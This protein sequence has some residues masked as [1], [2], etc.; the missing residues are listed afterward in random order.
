MNDLTDAVDSLMRDRQRARLTAATALDDDPDDAARAQQLSLDTGVP[1]S[2]IHGDLEGFERT[3]KGSLNK[4]LI[5]N[6]PHLQEYVNSHPMAA[7]VSHDDFHNLDSVTDAVKAIGS[8]GV[9]GFKA[10]FDYP[11]LVDEMQK[12]HD[13]VDSPLWKEFAK[14]PSVA[15]SAA[16]IEAGKRIFSGAITAGAQLIGEAFYQMSG[17]RAWADRLTRDMY[18]LAQ[19]S[20][21]GQAGFHLAPELSAHA[22]VAEAAQRV[23][24]GVKAAE[25]WLENNQLPPRGIHPVFDEAWEEAS[26]DDI[27]KLD[28]ALRTANQSKTRERSPELFS[29]FVKQIVGNGKIEIDA[30]AVRKLYGED[31]PE[32][33]DGKLGWVPN[34]RQQLETAEATGGSIEVPISEWLARVDPEIAKGLREDTRVR[35]QGMTLKEIEEGEERKEA[36]AKE[37]EEKFEPEDEPPAEDEV[38]A[39]RRV[40]GIEEPLFSEFGGRIRGAGEY[41]TSLIPEDAEKGGEVPHPTGSEVKVPRISGTTLGNLIDRLDF[42]NI[43]EGDKL[44]NEFYGKRLKE[45]VGNVPVHIVGEDSMEQLLSHRPGKGM[46]PGYYSPRYDHI[47]LADYTVNGE[48]PGWFTTKLV[49]H[50]GDHALNSPA[51]LKYPVLNAATEMV[52]KDADIHIAGK[53]AK[54]RKAFDYAFQNPREFMAEVRSRPALRKWLAQAPASLETIKTVQKIADVLGIKDKIVSTWDAVRVIFKD[55]YNRVLGRVPRDSVLDQVF[56]L[57]EILE[58]ANVALEK[59]AKDQGIGKG[60]LLLKAESPDLAEGDKPMF[61]KMAI[62]MNKQWQEKYFKLIEKRNVEDMEKQFKD[63]ERDER[64]RQTE[65]WKQ[66]AQK[67]YSTVQQDL[68]GRPD[69]AIGTFFEQGTIFGQ[70][71]SAKPILDS[72]KLSAEQKAILPKA[73]FGR[74]GIDPDDLAG[75]FGLRSGDEV[76]QVLAQ[77]NKAKGDM[78]FKEYVRQIT[79]KEVS[80]R[81][82]REHGDLEENIMNEAIGHVIGSTQMDILHEELVGLGMRLGRELP[83]TKEDTKAFAKTKFDSTPVGQITVEKMLR[84]AGKAGTDAEL[85][86]LDNKPEEAFQAKQKQYLSMRMADEAKRFEKEQRRFDKLTKQFSAR[87]VKSVLPEYTNFIHQILMQIG[88]PVRRS[89]QDLQAAIQQSGY[90]DLAGFVQAKEGSLREM[91]VAEFLFDPN[92]K[93]QTEDMSVGELRAVINSVKTLVHNGKDEMKI[94]REGEARDLEEVLTEMK[95]KLEDL[96]KD[97]APPIDRKLNPAIRTI[98]TYWASSLTTESL[99]NRWD[100]DD[101]RGIFNRFITYPMAEAANHEARLIR[102]FQQHLREAVGDI[103]DVDKKITNDLFKDPLTGDFFDM[104][105]RNVLGIL[106][107]IGNRS[108]LE[109]LAKGYDLEPMQVVNWVLSHTTKEDWDRAQRI[110]DIFSRLSDMADNMAYNLSGVTFEKLPIESLETPFGRYRGWYNPIKYDP[111]R[112]GRSKKLIGPNALEEEGYFRAATPQGYTKGR[113]G[114]IAPVEL[115]LDVVPMRIKQM[116]HDIAFRPAVI[117]TSK[118]FYDSGFQRAVIKNYG[119]VYAKQLVPYLKD[120]ANYSNSMSDAAATGNRAIEWFRQNLISTLVGFNP[121]TVMKHGMTA[122][123]N[124]LTE[125]GPINF[126]RELSGLV[127]NSEEAGRNNW[128]FAMEHS[129]ELQRRMR[130][131]SELIQGQPELSLMRAS[132]RQMLIAAGST[133]IAVGDLL[134]AVPTWLARYRTAI[135]EGVD[136]GQ[137]VAE[138]N[139]AVRR[140]HGSSAITNRAQIMRS[141]ALGATFSSLYGF[142]SHMLNKQFELSWKAADSFQGLK[143]GDLSV[144]KQ[145]TPALLMGLV[146][147]VI[148]PAVVE[149][150]VTPYTNSERDSWGMKAVKTLGKGMSS[151]WIGVRDFVDGFINTREGGA[152]LIPTAFKS[153]YDISKDLSKGKK[154]MNKEEA[155]RTIKHAFTAVGTLSGLTNAQEGRTAEFLYRY[156]KGLEHPKGPMDWAR[157]MTRGTLKEYRR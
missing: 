50:E 48:M 22:K 125:V 2:V 91:P 76:V 121:H 24:Q 16:A 139:R 79:T 156:H 53:D 71:V 127:M 72:S 86:L 113:T 77:I 118:V 138:G 61:G 90:G 85:A 1:A 35:P 41:S 130:N 134:S 18:A 136:H 54:A 66:D 36:E 89:V 115:N 30:E 135:E 144:V 117:E 44:L 43:D 83:F 120:V 7:K 102:E 60:D 29:N 57:N 150:L 152:G 73:T 70:K 32:P 153:I 64:K 15:G 25:P 147:Y 81:M 17:S 92:F 116:I 93:K 114:Y 106:Q 123:V 5:D 8:A 97:K 155:G 19:V 38:Q 145:H 40:A 69:I 100:K 99:L 87:E 110:G 101:P 11:G 39:A 23:S 34:L 151:S 63:A 148:F 95:G 9:E 104:R 132:P 154:V 6:N 96:G 27:K 68:E 157:G 141:N 12:F 84:D 65:Q 55:L 149:E 111:N 82:L 108:N 122:A 14:E 128:Q 109:K 119:E 13:Y 37:R 28:D 80:R 49:L 42:S 126:L 140:A 3:Y 88:R 26:K 94:I 105:K 103:P 62:G 46:A 58:D 56:K 47:V 75:A 52:M 98:K 112:P 45:L 4:T 33:D 133:P 74:G 20:M 137:A 10:G 67:M 31:V 142:F 129:E 131:W 107:N 146:S 124:S 143:A 21:A 59:M 78:P 51:L